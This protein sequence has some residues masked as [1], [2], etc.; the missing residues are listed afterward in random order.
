MVSLSRA[1]REGRR[2]VQRQIFGSYFQWDARLPRWRIGEHPPNC[3]CAVGMALMASGYEGPWDSQSAAEAA[4]MR[5]GPSLVRKAA[6]LN[7][8]DHMRWD[9]IARRL[10]LMELEW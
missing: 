2:L 7:D 9:R 1:I 10:E 4:S 3:A 5:W 8:V 6:T